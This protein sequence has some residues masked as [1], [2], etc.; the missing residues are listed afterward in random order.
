MEGLT[1]LPHHCQ[2]RIVPLDV[3]RRIRTV[4]WR[5]GTGKVRGVHMKTTFREYIHALCREDTTYF[6]DETFRNSVSVKTMQ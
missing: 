3:S 5:R 6:A 2:Q 1:S 4:K